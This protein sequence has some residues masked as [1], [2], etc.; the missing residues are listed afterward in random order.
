MNPRPRAMSNRLDRPSRIV[1][2][3]PSG[4]CGPGGGDWPETA[5]LA[6]LEARFR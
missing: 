5:E 6:K 3:L 4:H 2:M 1:K